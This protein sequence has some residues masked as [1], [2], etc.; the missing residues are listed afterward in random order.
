MTWLICISKLVSQIHQQETLRSHVRSD[1]SPVKMDLDSIKQV[2]RPKI[3]R[4]YKLSINLK[5]GVN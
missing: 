5:N 1:N 4:N 2:N 3:Y